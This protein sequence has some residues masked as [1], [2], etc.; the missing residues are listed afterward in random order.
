MSTK[1]AIESFL[2]EKSI[3]VVGVSRSGRKFGNSVYNELR[4]KGYKVFPINPHTDKIGD[5]PC[6]ANLA[7]VPE[8]VGGVVAV[9]PPE[10][11]REI[12]KQAKEAGIRKMWLQRGSESPEV[13]SYCEEQGIEAV[14]GECILMFA[15]PVASFH[16][17]HRFFRSLF[18]KMPK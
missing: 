17:V 12:A 16:K 5:D 18:G 2:E 15:D 10:V 1:K 14:H 6:Y 8:A 7:A 9:V 13:I 4:Q 3:A 11:T